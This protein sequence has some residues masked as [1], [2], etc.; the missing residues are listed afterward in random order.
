MDSRLDVSSLNRDQLIFHLFLRY[1]PFPAYRY[2]TVLF[3]GEFRMSSMKK[4]IPLERDSQMSFKK[5][6]II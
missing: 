1:P 2:L 3:P 6:I 4:M 5:V